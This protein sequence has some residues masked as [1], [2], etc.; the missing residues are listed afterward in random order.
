M[1][2]LSVI[3]MVVIKKRKKNLLQN[4][5]WAGH[6]TSK[7]TATWATGHDMKMLPSLRVW[8]NNEENAK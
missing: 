6:N 3:Y 7:H 1:A 2:S 8:S 5:T 4:G